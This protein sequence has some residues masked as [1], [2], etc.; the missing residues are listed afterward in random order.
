MAVMKSVFVLHLAS[1]VTALVGVS[2]WTT[3]APSQRVR[4]AP[5]MFA[6]GSISTISANNLKM[7]DSMRAYVEE[8][9]GMVVEKY[10]G[11][12]QRCDTHLSVMRNPAVRSGARRSASS[13]PPLFWGPGGPERGDG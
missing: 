12:A 2:P 13:G 1:T 7:T 8:K 11:V 3:P 10:G 6:E 5:T 4:Q 9:I